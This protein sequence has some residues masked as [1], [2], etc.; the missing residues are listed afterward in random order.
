MNRGG[1]R[2]LWRFD[3]ALRSHHD[4]AV[5]VGVDE[6]GRGPLAGPVVA[7]AVVL[8]VREVRALRQV[9]DSKA[10]TLRVRE[11]LFGVIRRHALEF[12]V[13]WCLSD[14]IDRHNI[15][16][17][18]LLA[19][20]RATLRL[21]LGGSARLV[22]VDGNRDIPSLPHPQKA[23]ID[24]DAY[25]QSIAAASI[26]AKVVRDRW[27][28]RFDAR[29]PGYGFARHKGYATPDHLAALD[30]LGPCPIHRR[31]FAPVSQAGL[32]LEDAVGT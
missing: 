5:L 9:R 17:A 23:L 6:A 27:M 10:L 29:Y 3:E 18:S 12:A 32:P 1:V 22:A 26:L 15:L 4:V 25:S 24:G 20:R 28:E 30:R 13:G 11:E 19:M 2:R 16:Q 31:S 21:R 8:P 7:A 14:E